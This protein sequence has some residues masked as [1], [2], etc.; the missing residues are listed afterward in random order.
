MYSITERSS[1]TEVRQRPCLVSTG[2]L[3]PPLQKHPTVHST[4]RLLLFGALVVFITDKILSKLICRSLCREKAYRCVAAK[5]HNIKNVKNETCWL[6]TPHILQGWRR[7]SWRR[8]PVSR[9]GSAET[10]RSS[11]KPLREIVPEAFWGVLPGVTI[12]QFKRR[13]SAE[14]PCSSEKPIKTYCYWGRV[15]LVG[16]SIDRIEDKNI[17]SQQKKNRYALKH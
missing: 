13:G 5:D 3:K 15:S 6:L 17:R 7:G 11:K 8:R 12:R 4:L 14:T 10:P 9:K 16:V 2:F 1:L